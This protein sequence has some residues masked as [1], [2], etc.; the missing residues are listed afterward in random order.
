[1]AIWLASSEL[2]KPKD[3]DR[4]T[5]SKSSIFKYLIRYFVP[6]FICGMLA[7]RIVAQE[8]VTTADGF[9]TKFSEIP[10]LMNGRIKPLDSVAR[11]SMMIISGKQSIKDKESGE[12]IDANEWLMDSLMRPERSDRQKIFLIHHPE[13]LL[14][15]N[16]N[17]DRKYYSFEELIPFEDVITD[18]ARLA[19]EAEA[20]SRTTFQ[21]AIVKL[22][23]SMVLYY[24]LKN[25]LCSE[26]S[27]SFDQELTIL[28]RIIQEDNQVFDTDQEHAAAFREYTEYFQYVDRT[29]VLRFIPDGES[30]EWMTTGASL[31]NSL[32][33]G[34][35]NPAVQQLSRLRQAYR[36]EKVGEF[37][38]ALIEYRSQLKVGFAADVQRMSVERL[39][40]HVAPF[41]QAMVPYV[42]ALLAVLFSWYFLSPNWRVAAM[43][44]VAVGFV[45]H[46]F[47][48]GTRIYLQGRPPVTNL[49]SSAV[50]IGWAS[51]LFCLGLERV[52]RRGVAAA[53]A[54][55]VGFATLVVAHHLS[56]DGDTMEMMQAVLDS[57]FWLATHVV[58]ITLG[59]SATFVAGFT[60]IVYVLRGLFSRSLTKQDSRDMQMMVYG[61]ICFA[62]LFSF[63]GTVLGGIWAD[64][65]WGRFW[66]WDPKENGALMIVIWNAVILHMRL[67]GLIKTRGLMI[68]AIIGNMITAFSWFGVNLLG[69]G[70]HS[71]GFLEKTF[72][73]FIGFEVSQLVI[74]ALAMVPERYWKS[75]K[76]LNQIQKQTKSVSNNLLTS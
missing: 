57:N 36:E 63:V 59:Y 14:M 15:V 5:F 12:K 54:A 47:G 34:E 64:Q 60:G 7:M 4:M 66:G 55:I 20:Q 6:L 3:G 42:C 30:R 9:S 74:I 39:F 50:F 53:I 29:A 45:I 37:N 58:T 35:I 28:G 16:G 52:F 26:G 71:Y 73:A 40:N 69:I 61:T 49:Y 44:F 65:S 1:M 11:N 24:R 76:A 32:G 10:V 31:L 2:F 46:T 38:Q 62:L 75:W 13:V 72:K 51:V 56:G 8:R 19:H 25:S 17:T 33:R 41:R 27:R 22:H 21:R 68:C 23:D 18:Q 48:L 43:I 67:G 70:L